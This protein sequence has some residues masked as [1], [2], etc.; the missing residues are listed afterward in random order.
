MIDLDT[1]VL[2]RYLTQDDAVQSAV[3][4]RLIE[5]RCNAD[6]PGWVTL[7][8][9]SELVWVLQRA[10]T[11]EKSLIVSVLDQILR[12]SDL[13]IEEEDIAWAALR[14]YRNG[15]ADFADDVIRV[16]WQ[17]AE[18]IPLVAYDVRLARHS[19]SI[20]VENA[21]DGLPNGTKAEADAG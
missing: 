17:N 15:S 5:S 6:S 19:G 12:S 8:V 4:T 7:A 11:Y 18:A 16:G 20:L 3:A 14:G 21:V 2:V 9:L 1:H 13:R 10:Y